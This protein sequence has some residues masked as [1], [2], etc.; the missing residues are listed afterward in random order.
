MDYDEY[1]LKLYQLFEKEKYFN[2]A[3]LTVDDTERKLFWTNVHSFENLT[4][5]P[6]FETRH[7]GIYDILNAYTVKAH[8]VNFPQNFFDTNEQ[9][10]QR[11]LNTLFYEV[12]NNLQIQQQDLANCMQSN[13]FLTI[14]KTHFSC[15]GM[16]VQKL[17]FQTHI[18][19]YRNIV[20]SI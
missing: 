11:I 12:K 17:I 3:V 15:I 20:S 10:N 13:N 6:N 16:F 1:I 18:S 8:P 5:L 9:E 19:N 2:Y 14:I 7:G 4:N